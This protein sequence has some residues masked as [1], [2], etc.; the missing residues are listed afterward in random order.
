MEEERKELLMQVDGMQSDSCTDKVERAIKRLDP[1]AEVTIDLPHG[2]VAVTTRA[3]SLEVA[4][5]INKAG[6]EARAMSL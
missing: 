3:Q 2:R 6:F 4:E 1:A 5:A